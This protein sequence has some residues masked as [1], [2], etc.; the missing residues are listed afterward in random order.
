MADTYGILTGGGDVPGLNSVIKS[1]VYR[2]TEMGNRVIGIRRGWEGLTHAGPDHDDRYVWPLD[3][4]NTRT[5]DRTGGTV[6]HTSRCNPQRTRRSEAPS[7]LPESRLEAMATEDDL[8]DLTPVVLDNLD[9]LGIDTLVAIGGDDTL[10]YAERIHREGFPVMAIPKTMDNDVRGTEYCIGFSTAVTRA[11]E[12]ITRQRTTIGS[13]ERTAVFRI[14]GR[15]AGFTA[16]YTGYVTSCRCL[17]PEHPF[18]PDHLAAILVEDKRDNPS[19]YAIVIASEGAVWA[20]QE[21]REFGEADAYGHKKKADI[22]HALARELSTR[23]GHET[24][25][26]DL[27]YDLRSGDPDSVD[28]MVAITFA[29]LALDLLA[30]GVTGR[31]V[32]IREGR[33]THTEIPDPALGPRRVDVEALYDTERY[34]PRYVGKLGAPLLLD[35]LG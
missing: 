31:M 19:N 30:D 10:S 29:N 22:G 14:F 3:R 16:L 1:V 33:Y 20:G 2:S 15:D 11:K 17:I 26:S 27:T 32:A 35:S 28:H 18:D 34:R 13:H 4:T 25:T 23:T 21:V 7:H 8:V 9:R 24:L 6:L 5:I 12:L